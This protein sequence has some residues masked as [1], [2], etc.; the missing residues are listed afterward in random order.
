M[1]FFSLSPFSF[2]LSSCLLRVGGGS[3]SVFESEVEALSTPVFFKFL[4]ST[5]WPSTP[6]WRQQL[7]RCRRGLDFRAAPRQQLPTSLPRRRR[8]SLDFGASRRRGL[9]ESAARRDLTAV[10][11]IWRKDPNPTTTRLL[12]SPLRGRRRRHRRPPPMTS[13][14]P[15]RRRRPIRLPFPTLPHSSSL[16]RFSHPH[17]SSTPTVTTLGMHCSNARALFPDGAMILSLSVPAAAH[18]PHTPAALGIHPGSP[19]IV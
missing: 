13:P 17:D 5:H 14:P 11:R 15:G 2:S 16:L 19:T 9:G 8:R 7:C 1:S 10:V 3:P 4:G 12:A 6:A 18:D